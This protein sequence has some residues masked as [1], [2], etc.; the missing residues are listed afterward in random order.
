MKNDVVIR[1]IGSAGDGLVSIGLLFG[2]ILKKHGLN[3]MGFR[4]YQSVI[5][6][7]YNNYQIRVAKDEVLSIGEDAD[8]IVL[9]NKEVALLHLP[10]VN[11]GARIIYDPEQMNLDELGYPKDIIKLPIPLDS[12]TKS[13][14]KIKV[15]KNI[16]GFGVIAYIM[17]LDIDIIKEVIQEQFG[18][19]GEEVIKLNY[20][21]LFAGLEY[22]ESKE[23]EHIWPN[24]VFV[25][26]HQMI[27]GGNESAAL[28]LVAGG[29]KYFSGYPIT[30]AS[31][32]LHYLTRYLPSMRIIVKQTEDEIAAVAMAVGASYCGAR[33]ATAS[34]GAGFALK[35][36][37]IGMAAIQEVPLVIISSQRAGPSTGMATKVEQA[38][39]F[40]VYGASQGDFPKMI[41]AASSV[42][43]AFYSAMEALEFA[44]RFQL[45]VIVLLDLYLSEM[46]ATIR[47]LPIKQNL[48]RHSIVDYIE[49]PETYKRY[50]FTETG[51]SP[52]ALPGTKNGMHFT[53]SSEHNEYGYSI[54]STKSGLPETLPIREKMV[55]K[56]HRKIE[57]LKNRLEPPKIE[58]TPDAEV[59]LVSWGST[60]SIVK[61]AMLQLEAEGIT[62]NHLHFKY[63]QPFHSDEVKEIF[64][65]TKNSFCVEMNFSGQ[66]RNFIRLEIGYTIPYLINRYDGELIVPSQIVNKVKEVLK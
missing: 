61:E 38:D 4:S 26:T 58:G 37:I 46:I 34:S 29:L 3:V 40:Q 9:L 20:S 33:S 62:T 27:M 14:T 60:K 63:I 11:K 1:F 12:M 25:K 48:V 51:V 55:Q 8:I 19:K 35:T 5:R 57:V 44:E 18:E 41:I 43:D 49:T 66:L 64:Q 21:A 28:G 17:S 56:R 6:G 31:S 22:C 39:L 54:A 45:V 15:I 32:I 30:P 10:L 65:K 59:T 36:E 23:W 53:G 16:I 2:K 7:G 52:R 50:S 47:E 24:Q 42:E 13:L